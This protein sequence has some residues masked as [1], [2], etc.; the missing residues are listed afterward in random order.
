VVEVDNN[1]II[2]HVL[3]DQVVV[4]H[5]VI[6]ILD[7]IIQVAEE[8]EVQVRQDPLQ[9]RELVVTVAQV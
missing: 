6:Q 1:T 5:Q 4:D 9:T 2:L 8:E 7:Q 3:E